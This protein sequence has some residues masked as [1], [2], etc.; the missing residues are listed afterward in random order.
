MLRRSP[1]FP[2][3]PGNTTP[4]ATFGNFQAALI[5]TGKTEEDIQRRATLEV[6]SP[7]PIALRGYTRFGNDMLVPI[8]Y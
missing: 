5:A 2:N 4:D 6:F 3:W 1:S 7:D 8:V